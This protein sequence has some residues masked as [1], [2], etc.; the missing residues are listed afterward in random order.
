M[1]YDPDFL[2]KIRDAQMRVVAASEGLDA[3][4]GWSSTR[5][6][7]RID[8]W[9][10][11]ASIDC[12]VGFTWEDGS[13]CIFDFEQEKLLAWLKHVNEFRQWPAPTMHGRK[14]AGAA[15]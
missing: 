15:S 11:R 2:V 8:I 10:G 5:P 14:D 6:L 7:E 9:P 12:Q 3:L 13:T 4:L 1:S